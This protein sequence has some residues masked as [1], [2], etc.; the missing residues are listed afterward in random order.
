MVRDARPRAGNAP[1]LPRGTAALRSGIHKWL[2]LRELDGLQ[3]RRSG[4]LG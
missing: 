1:S 2:D 3:V 4:A